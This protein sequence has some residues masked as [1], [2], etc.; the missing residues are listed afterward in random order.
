MISK[1]LYDTREFFPVK[2]FAALLQR[3]VELV[4]D[5]LEF[6]PGDVAKTLPKL[7]L[8]LV[9]TL[10]LDNF[11]LGP[12]LEILVVIKLLL[13]FLVKFNEVRDRKLVRRICH[14]AIQQV[15]DEHAELCAPI[16]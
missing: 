8:E 2:A 7:A 9:L 10:Q 5:A 6:L 13:C 12:G 16:A 3:D 11:F 15:S 1:F 14:V 4:V